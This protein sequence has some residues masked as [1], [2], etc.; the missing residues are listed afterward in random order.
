MVNVVRHATTE[1]HTKTDSIGLQLQVECWYEPRVGRLLAFGRD[2]PPSRSGPKAPGGGGGG[3]GHWKGGG[4]REGRWGGSGRGD[5]GGGSGGSVGGGGVQIG[6]FG[7]VGGGGGIGTEPV[8]PNPKILAL[9]KADTAWGVDFALWLR[10][11]R[12]AVFMEWPKRP[13]TPAK[14]A[15]ADW[16]AV[17]VLIGTKRLLLLGTTHRRGAL[18]CYEV[19]ATRSKGCS[20][21]TRCRNKQQRWHGRW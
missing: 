3:G 15:I 5:G 7:V 13:A 4:F 1:N 17:L 11:K 2:S 12:W 9:T 18:A 19:L 16:R 10:H 20:P 14:T 6:Q 21:A 8:K